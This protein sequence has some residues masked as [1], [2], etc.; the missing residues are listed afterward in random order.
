M[1]QQASG[2]P[3]PKLRSLVPTLDRDMETI[4][5]KCLEREPRAR[6]RS[7]E[8]LAEDLERWLDGRPISARRVQA[9]VRIWR[10]SKRNPIVATATASAVIFAFAAGFLF[11]S[12]LP[13]TA[14]YSI[15]QKHRSASF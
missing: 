12:Q 4:C 15:R 10:W 1:I 11:F 13:G 2:G 8:D 9:P 3:A 7:A 5:G 14:G 6:Y